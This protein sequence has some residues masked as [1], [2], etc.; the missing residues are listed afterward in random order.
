MTEA[1]NAVLEAEQK[2]RES[3]SKDITE[4]LEALKILNSNT[5]KELE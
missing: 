5:I 1:K 4:E 3:D 2:V